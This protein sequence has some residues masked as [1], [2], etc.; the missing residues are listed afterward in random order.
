MLENYRL[1]IMTR[2]TDTT[3]VVVD[4]YLIEEIELHDS[5]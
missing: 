1:E 3:V 4:S 5:I 2:S